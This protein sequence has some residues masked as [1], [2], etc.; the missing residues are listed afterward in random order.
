M[1]KP[2]SRRGFTLIELLVVIAIIAVLISLLLPAVQQAR[3]AARRTQCKNSL[4]QIG[5]AIHNYHETNNTIPP[6]IVSAAPCYINVGWAV[7]I[8]PYIDN[9][10]IYQKYNF[11][12]NQKIRNSNPGGAVIGTFR[13]GSDQGR[14]RLTG[15]GVI[16]NA[17]RSNYAGVF[18]WARLEGDGYPGYNYSST[19]A[20]STPNRDGSFHVNSKRNFSVFRDGLS[21]T[22]M[23]AER[24]TG[25]QVQGNRFVG[26]PTSICGTANP[27]ELTDGTAVAAGNTGALEAPDPDNGVHGIAQ[28]D[29]FAGSDLNIS[30]VLGT[31]SMKPNLSTGANILGDK[32]D[33]GDSVHE[34]FSS[35]HIGIVNGLLGDGS[36]RTFSDNI[37][38]AQ[39]VN[40]G[41]A[42][43][44]DTE[45]WQLLSTIDDGLTVG[46]Y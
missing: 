29:S 30:L 12:I 28:I 37:A 19:N 43:P 14:N 8:L 32:Q 23:V 41:A 21:N 35:A 4:K 11:N 7:Y 36:V 3:E 25:S 40:S 38:S 13:C 46:D 22:L 5:L 42:L 31:T 39:T 44:L 20:T 34:G 24:R 27:V 17:G 10:P 16:A 2:V 18:G 26:G 33:A 1:A 15:P 6:G 45:I 9:A